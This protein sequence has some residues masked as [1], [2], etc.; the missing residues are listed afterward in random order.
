MLLFLLLILL[1]SAL[2]VSK[3]FLLVCLFCSQ[4]LLCSFLVDGYDL[5]GM[6]QFQHPQSFL[7][8]LRGTHAID[9]PLLDSHLLFL[10]GCILSLAGAFKPCLRLC[11]NRLVVVGFGNDTLLFCQVSTGKNLLPIFHL[12]LFE[13]FLVLLIIR[14]PTGIA[15]TDFCLL[16]L[17]P[18]LFSLELVALLLVISAITSTTSVAG[19]ATIPAALGLGPCLVCK[20]HVPCREVIDDA[21]QLLLLPVSRFQLGLPC[22]ISRR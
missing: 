6:I 16:S 10:V 14:L 21:V 9:V 12:Y 3:Q 18:F 7:I 20:F 5:A 4:T 11:C 22:P 8:S 13:A 1:A 19:T 15:D 2:R 17:A